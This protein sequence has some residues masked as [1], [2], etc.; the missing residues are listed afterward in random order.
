MDLRGWEQVE[1]GPSIDLPPLAHRLA[2]QSSPRCGGLGASVLTEASGG[3]HTPV[4]LTWVCGPY[5]GAVRP[6]LRGTLGKCCR[7]TA[8]MFVEDAMGWPDGET[9]GL[10]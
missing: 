2:T 1:W 3:S 10:T 7:I 5:D 6:P 9:P 4:C 8:S